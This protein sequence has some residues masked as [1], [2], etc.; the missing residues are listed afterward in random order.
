MN[1][2]Q[3]LVAHQ[4]PNAAIFTLGT[5]SSIAAVLNLAVVLCNL[6][7]AHLLQSS[8]FLSFCLCCTDAINNIVNMIVAGF[9]FFGFDSDFRVKACHVAG[10]TTFTGHSS[11]LLLILGLTCCRYSVIVRQENVTRRAAWI[12]ASGAVILT[13]LVYLLP[14][15]LEPIAQFNYTTMPSGI[16]CGIGWAGATQ[17]AKG[18]TLIVL[19]L[20]MLGPPL[21]FILYVYTAISIAMKKSVA[22]VRKSLAI[23]PALPAIDNLVAA[24][25]APHDSRKSSIDART[26]PLNESDP[27]SNSTQNNNSN[28]MN[29][30][31]KSTGSKSFSEMGGGVVGGSRKSTGSKSFSEAMVGRKSVDSKSRPSTTAIGIHPSLLATLNN[32]RL[33]EDQKELL[34]QSILIVVSFLVGWTPYLCMMIYQIVTN[35]AAP[36]LMDF[37]SACSVVANETAGPII[38]LCYNRDI[39]LNVKKVFRKII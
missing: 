33:V 18:I 29:T 10:Y 28:P 15:L 1:S 8:S 35:E 14:L 2:T 39:R 38:L 6:T 26:T 3:P 11:S 37:V 17:D 4:I 5:L 31:R 19:T 32:H 13:A 7:K 22:G 25:T 12:F 24:A 30:K 9:K 21:C 34:K 36:P 27:P 23:E 20:L 16:Y